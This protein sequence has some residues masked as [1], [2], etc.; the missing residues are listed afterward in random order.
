MA[1]PSR[2]SNGKDKNWFNIVVTSIGVLVLS[3][4]MF[5]F[6]LDTNNINVIKS[7]IQHLR[8]QQDKETTKPS[9]TG[10]EKNEITQQPTFKSPTIHQHST[11]SALSPT[12][13]IPD[14]MA[15]KSNINQF[16][17]NL[18]SP[19]LKSIVTMDYF[20][21][22]KVNLNRPCKLWCN[23]DKCSMRDCKVKTLSDP[24]KCPVATYDDELSTVN[25]EMA[26]DQLDLLIKLFECNDNDDHDTQYVDLLINPERYTGYS[27][28]T[29]H[30]VWRAIYE[31]NCFIRRSSSPFSVEDM[32]YEERLFYEAISGLHSS[33]NIHLCA[34]YPSNAMIGAF[35]PNLDEFLGRFEG[36]NDYLENLYTLFLLEL[37]ALL[38]SE[39]YLMKRIN[40]P[41]G[42]TKSAIQ[43]LLTVVSKFDVPMFEDL[44]LKPSHVYHYSHLAS[45]FRNIT[46]TII[47]CVA[48]DKCK[49][50][51]KVQL[52][53]LGTVFKILSVKDMGKL[54]LNHQEVVSLIN[55]IARLSHSIRQ[56]EEFKEL[57]V[58]KQLETTT[59]KKKMIGPGNGRHTDCKNPRPM[60]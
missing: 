40:W 13:S 48:C 26:S 51:G 30:R 18:L 31:E 10:D 33:I 17:R 42:S 56:L 20:R 32:C 55:A 19:L 2:P 14:F 41:D 11:L 21:Y 50:W 9:I 22:V 12:K 15:T 45:H 4:L 59:A 27:G 29:A 6:L 43:D 58:T 53:G 1:E 38:A 37:R 35:E 47:D 5:Y 57:I 7:T 54:S 23:S 36:H 8:E 34:E 52:R 28:E 24:S 46:T 39:Q 16:N 3:I 44:S 25:T 60:F 49:L